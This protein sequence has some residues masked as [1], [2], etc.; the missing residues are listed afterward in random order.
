G[1]VVY[2]KIRPYLRKAW[3]S[4]RRCLCSADMYPITA[5][6]DVLPRFLLAVMLSDRFSDYTS[7]VSM[8]TGI[9]KINREELSGYSVALPPREEQE[10]I[11]AVLDGFDRKLE[12]DE[13]L[14]SSVGILKRGL[15]QDLLTGRVRV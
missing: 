4:D 3:L 14:L 10:M 6:P 15:M 11:A 9:P 12:H 8:R 7:A 1:D 5:G 2:S 13:A